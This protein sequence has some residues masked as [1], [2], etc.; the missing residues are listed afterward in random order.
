MTEEELLAGTDID[1]ALDIKLD[2]PTYGLIDVT[3][4]RVYF[5]F[6]VT[7]AGTYYFYSGDASSEDTYGYLYNADGTV[8]KEADNQFPGTGYGG[9]FGI[10]YELE[11]GTYY[12]AAG[13]YYTYWGE[14]LGDFYVVLSTTKPE[15]HTITA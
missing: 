13:Y 11:A 14:K 5:K 6:T 10:E 3:N 15:S 12:F 8:I 1:H 4:E 7:E 9:H 2:T